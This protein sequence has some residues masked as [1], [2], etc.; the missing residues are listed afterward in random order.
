M[1]FHFS[2]HGFFLIARS[3]LPSVLMCVIWRV[4]RFAVS[5]SPW[6]GSS[7]VA[8]HSPRAWKTPVGLAQSCVGL[9]AHSSLKRAPDTEK[10]VSTCW[11]W[12]SLQYLGVHVAAEVC[13]DLVLRYCLQSTS[14]TH[15]WCLEAWDSTRK[16]RW[17]C[18]PGFIYWW[19]L[20]IR[21]P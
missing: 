4:P 11:P 18:Q 17:L 15:F 1:I 3:Q 10:M 2:R 12:A 19:F 9:Q 14:L 5:F 16:E 21:S 8:S 6:P 7:W 13:L 20:H